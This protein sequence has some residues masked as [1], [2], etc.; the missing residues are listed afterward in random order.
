[1]AKPEFFDRLGGAYEALLKRAEWHEEQARDYRA[2]AQAL[3][4]KGYAYD[5]DGMEE[6]RRRSCTSKRRYRTDKA[7]GVAA[8]HASI[9]SGD[10]LRT[11]RCVFCGGWHLTK[12]SLEAFA[13]NHD[14][15]S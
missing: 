8:A 12:T 11:Y 14:K 4:D 9:S 13:E 15:V 5:H 7:A 6:E 2:R 10:K 1:M 3:K